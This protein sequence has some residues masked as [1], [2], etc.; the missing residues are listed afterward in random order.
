MWKQK[1]FKT[2]QMK[3][4]LKNCCILSCH[5]CSC[6]HLLSSSGHHTQSVE[7]EHAQLPGAHSRLDKDT[8][9]TQEETQTILSVCV[10]AIKHYI[11]GQDWKI[12]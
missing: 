12:Q 3:N 4:S 9:H 1:S 6:G 7:G 5:L 11:Y 8:H 2:D 10:L